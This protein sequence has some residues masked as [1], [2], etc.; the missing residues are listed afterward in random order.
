[1]LCKSMN[2]KQQVR[3][4]R[5]MHRLSI[6]GPTLH[7][8][9]L[10]EHMDDSFET[11]ILSGKLANGET[12]PEELL[13]KM[14]APVT[15]ISSMER[16]LGLW[17][18]LKALREIRKIIREYKPDIVHTHAAKSGA[19]GRVAAWI[20]NVPVIIHTYHGHVFHSY[21]GRVKTFI[22]I[23]IERF[24]ARISS[25]IITISNQQFD[26]IAHQ[27]KIAPVSKF[28]IIPL[29]FDFSRF[30]DENGLKRHSFRKEFGM[31]DG[32]IALCIAGRITAIKNHKMFF[33]AL[34]RVF[35]QHEKG[36]YAFVVG[37]GEMKDELISFCSEKGLP[38]TGT[39]TG[40]SS[41]IFTSWRSDMENVFNGIDICCL[42]SLNEGTPVTAI[43]AMYCKKPVVSTRVGGVP[44]VVE[45]GV[46]GILTPSNE[47]EPFANALLNLIENEK[48]RYKI[49]ENARR[50]AENFSIEKLV[51]ELSGLF[52]KLIG[53]YKSKG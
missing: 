28:N 19:L 10:S 17:N 13:Q 6:S 16:E 15:Y 26:E 38:V 22:F 40:K 39:A 50:G 14:K 41:V 47:A 45:D 4:L 11:R 30:R 1:M 32:D 7:A 49:G 31:S 29:G 44:D 43:E 33:K 18:D 42:T 52:L 51:S 34:V 36:V 35:S 20:E 2:E 12:A 27:F 8:Y 23:S 3:V 5:I 24:L 46:S 37:D 53:N 25:S 48:V 9:F 21:F